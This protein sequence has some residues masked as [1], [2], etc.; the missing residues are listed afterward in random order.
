MCP[1]FNNANFTVFYLFRI[2]L[3]PPGRL[4]FKFNQIKYSKNAITIQK[5]TSVAA[6]KNSRLHQVLYRRNWGGLLFGYGFVKGPQ[7]S[8]LVGG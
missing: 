2:C 8:K 7:P 6:I 1:K 3:D 5:T 4:F